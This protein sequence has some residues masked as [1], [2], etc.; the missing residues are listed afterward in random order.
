VRVLSF[1]ADFAQVEGGKVG[2]FGLG[3]TTCSSP[4]PP[5]AF[6]IFIDVEWDEVRELYQVK[7]DLLGVNDQPVSLPGPSGPVPVKFEFTTGMTLQSD[8]AAGTQI[9]IPITLNV[10]G[11]LPLELGK[12][13][14]RVTVEGFEADAGFAPFE[15]MSEVKPTATGSGPVLQHQDS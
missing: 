1:L 7:I 15:V 11:S 3:W 10:Q 14:W 2:A 6:V 8:V 9:R 13:R 5:F 12:Y 4:S